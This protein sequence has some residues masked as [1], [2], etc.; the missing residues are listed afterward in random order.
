MSIVPPSTFDRGF[1]LS[2]ERPSEKNGGEGVCGTGLDLVPIAGDSS[3]ESIARV[4]GDVATL[5]IRLRKPLSARL[6][7]VPGKQAGDDIRFTDPLLFPSKV[8][9]LEPQRS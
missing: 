6:F 8:M 2:P 3:P 4:I 7:L 1:P 5:A 9:E